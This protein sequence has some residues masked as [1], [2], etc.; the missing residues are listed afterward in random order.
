VSVGALV[1]HV[2]RMLGR[3]HALFGDPPDSGGAASSGAGVRLA[4][5]GE[6]VRSGQAR[7]AGSS[8]QFASSY[9]GF[10]GGAGAALDSL[11]GADDSLGDQLSQAAGS[12]RSG[13][14]ASGAVLT[15]AATDTTALAPFSGTPAGQQA[16]LSALRGRVAQQQKVIAA[17]KARDARLAAMLRST[18]YRGRSGVG[19]PSGLGGFGSA[20][21][22][23]GGGSPLPSMRALPGLAAKPRP[24]TVLAG[25]HIDHRADAVP[26]GPGGMA[27]AAA[28]SRRG[29]PYVWGAKG[30]NQFD[31]SG[32]TQWA[33]GQAGVQL[34]GDT[35]TQIT[36]GVPVPPGQ[37]RAGDLIFPTGSFDS[38]GPGHVQLAV[39]PTEVVHAPEPGDV[40]R[41]APMPSGYVARRPV[42][43][44]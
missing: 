1:E 20:G 27:V 22:S 18:A 26:A 30:P 12:D 36:Q 2:V 11:A 21:Q 7:I 44:A 10:A 42:P 16:L 32:L 19:M 28:L 3:A 6:L 38:R 40:V 17:Y 8:G 33:W 15:G 13:R 29:D 43:L 35:Y 4:R 14:T 39:S 25:R 41:V 37:V 23:G 9:H 31:C 34:G 5:A 24:Q